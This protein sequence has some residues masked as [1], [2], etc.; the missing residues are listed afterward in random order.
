[1]PAN[2]RRR[3]DRGGLPDGVWYHSAT[4]EVW[5][6]LIG[7]QVVEEYAFARNPL[8]PLQS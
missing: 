7:A 5:S 3:S 1:L 6:D 4:P 8:T 2:L